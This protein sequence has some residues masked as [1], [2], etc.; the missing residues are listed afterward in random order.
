MN[1][2]LKNYTATKRNEQGE[3]WQPHPHVQKTEQYLAAMK[4]AANPDAV[5]A[6][7]M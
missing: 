6:V 3:G 5:Q 7:R 4:T 2:L 1:I